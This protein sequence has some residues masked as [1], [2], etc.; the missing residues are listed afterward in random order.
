MTYQDERAPKFQAYFNR[1]LDGGL[2]WQRPDLRLDTPPAGGKSSDVHEPQ[3]VVS[4]TSWISAWTD[5]TYTDGRV[6][7][8]IVSRRTD[9]AGETWSLPTVLHQSD[10]HFSSLIVRAS[11]DSVVL[12]ADEL[13]KGVFALTSTDNGRN[14]RNSNALAG[15]AGL[16]NSGIAMSIADKRAHLVWMEQ[17]NDEKL[18][19]AAASLDVATARWAGDLKRLDSKTHDNTKSTSPTIM[20]T[21]R[22]ALVVAWVDYR[23]IRPNIYFSTSYDQGAAWSTPQ[24]LLNPGEVSA[25]W[26][27]LINVNGKTLLAYE[28]YPNERVAD[29]VLNVQTLPVDDGA[30]AMSRYSTFAQYNDTQKLEK[31][32]QRIDSLWA[33]RV[34]GNYAAAYD[35]FDFAY[36]AVTPKKQYVD[37]AGVISYLSFAVGDIKVVG[38][39]ASVDMK[40][41]YEMKPTIM[42]STGKP[43][44]VPPI[45][46]DSPTRWVWVWNNWYLVYTPSFEPPVLSY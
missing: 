44:S 36:K 41:K 15:T 40:L 28:T 20:A 9:D 34:A 23:D 16:S 42:P 3:T 12:A 7:Y 14:W 46:V 32:K 35:M 22:G 10:H 39:V 17:R 29:G 30:A 2:S 13:N 33:T 18:K 19:I 8:R 43:I 27:Q 1:S 25:G 11:G 24:A 5:N 31:L 37:N 4:G 45:E 38:N 6:L 26:P 21:E